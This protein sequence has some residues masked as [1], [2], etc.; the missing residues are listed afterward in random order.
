MDAPQHLPAGTAE[1]AGPVFSLTL[2]G[3]G[4]EPGGGGQIPL[5]A[6]DKGVA[7]SVPAGGLPQPLRQAGLA[8]DGGHILF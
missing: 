1:A 7:Q 8:G 2:H 5:A 3:R 6:E 4:G